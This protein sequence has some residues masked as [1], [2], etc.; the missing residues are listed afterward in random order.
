MEG[1]NVA[2]KLEECKRLKSVPGQ[3]REPFALTFRGPASPSL[4]QQI[5]TLSSARTGPVEIFLVP[6]ESSA[7]GIGYQ[8]IFN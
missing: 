5:Y 7:A 3:P 8:A 1:A 2:L 6:V 4:V